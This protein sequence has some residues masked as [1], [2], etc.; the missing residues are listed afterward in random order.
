MISSTSAKPPSR[1]TTSSVLSRATSCPTAASSPPLVPFLFQRPGQEQS[2]GPEGYLPGNRVQPLELPGLPQFP[3]GVHAYLKQAFSDAVYFDQ[4]RS[5]WLKDPKGQV[6]PGY[7]PNLEI[8][9]DFAT[10]RK[11]VIFLC[12][13]QNDIRRALG[14]AAEYKLVYFIAD[15][16]GEAFEV[17][18]ELKKSGARVLATVTF[19]AP[20]SSLY[21]QRGRAEREKA[22]KEVYPKNSARLAEAGIPFA[23]S[24]L[25]TDDPR[26]SPRGFR[27]PSRPACPGTRRSKHCPKRPP[28]FSASSGPSGRLSRGRSPVPS[29][30]RANSW[31]KTPR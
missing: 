21:A 23:F 14:L 25:G 28:P 2:P 31:P 22:E 4:A 8:L 11:P 1:N 24:S 17:I 10:A 9:A 6:R 18:P 20:G 16:G 27:R 5:R 19:K 7:N 15:L 26:P 29:S 12:R 3:D 13:N 30:R